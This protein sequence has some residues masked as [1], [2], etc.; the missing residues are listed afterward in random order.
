MPKKFGNKFIKKGRIMK[1]FFKLFSI[2][3]LLVLVVCLSFA[4]KKKDDTDTSESLDGTYKITVWVSE[5]EG[6]KE[7]TEKQIQDFMTAN[8]GIKIEATVEKVG[9]G[10]AA[11]QMIT[12]VEDGADLFCFAQDQLARLV[13]AGALNPLG[14]QESETITAEN[15]GGAVGA[16]TVDGKIYCYP[17]TSDNGYFMY[18][19]KRVISED[20]LGSLEDLIKACEDAGKGFSFNLE[21]SGWYNAS[22]FFATGCTST[23][24]LNATGEYTGV[25]DN[26][27]SDNGVIALK[28]MQKV[29]KSSAYVDSANGADFDAAKKSA[30]V[31]TGTWDEKTISKILGDNMGCAKLPS[32]TVDGKTYQLGSFSGNKLM[33]VKPQT[34]SKRNAVLQKLAVYLTG[35]KCQTERFEEVGW[36]PSNLKAQQSE[37]VKASPTL[38][39]LAAQNNFAIPQGQIHGSWWDIAKT[40]ATAARKATTDQDLK[41]ALK[42]YE[43]AINGLFTM[44]A[45]EKEAFTVIGKFGGYNW[46]TDIEMEQKPNGTWMTKE[47]IEF[48]EDD[49]F[50]VRQGKNWDVSFGVDGNNFIVAQDGKFYVKFV[51]DKDAGTGIVSLEKVNPNYGWTVIGKFE[52]NN[53]NADVYMEPDADGLWSTV[54]PI[55]FAAGD[56]FKVRFGLSWD[57]SYGDGTNNYAVTEAGSYHVTFNP[58]TQVVTLVPAE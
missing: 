57:V 17:L 1:R 30:V 53:W 56:E 21:G 48:K 52:E 29:L 22:F 2:V 10:E 11:T 45:D 54:E 28:G 8:P 14:Q 36:G 32:F 42:A 23:W 43:D 19:D 34:D 31:I 40:Y 44:P 58:E 16:A 46:D 4:C 15:D 20:K 47:P 41:D 5:I 3:A 24:Q 55:S 38:S 50:K 25:N 13:Q 18:Y 12:S 27:N 7:L 51:Y 26:F 9:E 37:A 39:A 35:E 33:G 6:V 49:E